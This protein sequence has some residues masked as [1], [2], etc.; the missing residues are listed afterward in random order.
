MTSKSKG[1]RKFQDV[2]FY[3]QVLYANYNESFYVPTWLRKTA[4]I[5]GK[6]LVLD[7]LVRVFL[8][9]MSILLDTLSKPNTTLILLKTDI[10]QCMKVQI[11][12][13]GPGRRKFAFLRYAFFSLPPEPHAPDS[14]GFRLI[15]KFTPSGTQFSR[16]WPWPVITLTFLVLWIIDD[17][18][19]IFGLY[20]YEMIS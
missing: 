13:N 19:G 18:L 2:Y 5:A 14:Q 1:L 16:P 7:M 4:H 12:Q 6:T 9:E 15:S 3:F 10:T 8:K 11:E 20:N 17:V